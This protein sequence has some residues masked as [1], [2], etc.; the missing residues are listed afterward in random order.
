MH[1]LCNQS[2]IPSALGNPQIALLLCE[3]NFV[4]RLKIGSPKP[5]LYVGLGSRVVFKLQENHGSQRLNDNVKIR[6]GRSA[7]YEETCT[8]FFLCIYV[9]TY[10]YIYI[11]TLSTG[12]KI[13]ILP[14]IQYAN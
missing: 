8:F 10:I 2:L 13:S 4:Q 6:S 1:E 12:L 7:M 14:V 5:T 9:Y 3:L 11:Y